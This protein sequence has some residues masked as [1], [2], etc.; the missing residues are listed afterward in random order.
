[1]LSMFISFLIPLLEEKCS[2]NLI[3]WTTHIPLLENDLLS[4]VPVT[5]RK[6]IVFHLYSMYLK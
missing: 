4:D 2:I 6:W 5:I 3:F 1:M